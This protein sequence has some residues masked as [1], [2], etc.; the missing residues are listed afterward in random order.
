MLKPPWHLLA[1][2]TPLLFPI[3]SKSLSRLWALTGQLGHGR[4]CR[5]SPGSGV[6]LESWALCPK[7][8]AHTDFW[9]SLD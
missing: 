1:E 3:A 7:A 6:L 2:P 5:S 8:V 4:G 9:L